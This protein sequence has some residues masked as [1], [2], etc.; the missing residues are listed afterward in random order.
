MMRYIVYV[1]ILPITRIRGFI[2]VLYDGEMFKIFDKTKILEFLGKKNFRIMQNF[3]LVMLFSC[4][5]SLLCDM[6]TIIIVQG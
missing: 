6:I 5:R 1:L 4:M 2:C 3:L